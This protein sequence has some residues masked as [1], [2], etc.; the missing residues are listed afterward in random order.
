[1]QGDVGFCHVL[2]EMGCEVH[3][4]ERSIS[5]KGGQ[6]RGVDIDMN[7]ISD[8][9][10]TLAVVALFAQGPTRVRG[11]AHNRFKET[12]RIGDLARELRKLGATIDE[13]EDGL[14]IHPIKA[15]GIDGSQGS[16]DR[17]QNA[18]DPAL[19]QSG[20]VLET[21]H[22]HRMAMSLSLAGLRIPGVRILD[23]ACT[24]KTYP[25]FFADL[26]K[27][28]GRAHRWIPAERL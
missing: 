18:E 6:L 3:D 22:D 28:T 7:H 13:H 26:E 15:A 4:G 11:V 5:V 17:P 19:T 20:V 10:Q 8:T 25:E 14:T 24:G 27:L 12:D 2:E 9:V 16:V 23:P 1:M 21:Y